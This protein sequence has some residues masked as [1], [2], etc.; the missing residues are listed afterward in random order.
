MNSFSL[1]HA[2]LALSLATPSLATPAA[3]YLVPQ[4]ASIT[5]VQSIG[6]QRDRGTP[7]GPVHLTAPLE[8]STVGSA[9]V[10]V[11]GN[12]LPPFDAPG[13]TVL[14]NGQSAGV[15]RV[16]R[17]LA[18]FV[19]PNVELAAGQNGIVVEALAPSGETRRVDSTVTFSGLNGNNVVLRGRFA[20]VAQGAAGLGVMTLRT[21]EFVTLPPPAG[22]N[23][24]DDVAVAD[25]FL[26]LLDA[27]TGGRLAVMSL[28]NPNAPVLVG[29]P[30]VVPVG[31]FAGVSAGGGRVV[32]SG[33]TGLMTVRSYDATGQ[34]SS[35]VSSIDLG[36]GQPDV[37]VSE[38]GLLAFVSTDFAGTFGGA[39][40]GLTTVSLG[41][42]LS[43]QSRT[44]LL[45]SGFT[46]GFQ[47]PANFPIAS[48]NIGDGVVVAH[49]GGLSRVSA[50]G[51]LIGS[52]SLGF[53]GVNVA[54]S[55]T[56]AFVVGS[57]RNLAQLEVGAAGQP[58]LLETVQ[59]PGPGVFTGV[60]VNERFVVIAANAGGLR[61]MSR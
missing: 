29:A 20:Y 51:S 49:G 50:Q 55:G 54:V 8:G 48:A 37:T 10:D 32:V 9:V 18:R 53:S 23:R 41:T 56:R 17:G 35:S 45:G 28:E 59:F 34:L 43:I 22:S 36:I 15:E 26:F 19:L 38:D 2:V 16:G 13:T 12:L 6:A 27:A 46:P 60:A 47:T 3:S 11:R 33:G 1:A 31:P 21:R 58:Q 39:G 52:Q 30:V 14:V 24:V 4:S 40:F 5:Q 7:F 44:G 57:N 25:G 61:V 42:P